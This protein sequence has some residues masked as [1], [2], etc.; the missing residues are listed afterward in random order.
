VLALGA[1]LVALAAAE[2]SLWLLAPVADPYASLKVRRAP[3]YVL[4]AN[5]DLRLTTDVEPGLPGMQGPSRFTTNRLGFGGDSLRI[6]KPPGELRVFLIG[7][8][9]TE[10]LYLD[11]TSSL[12]AVVQRELQRLAGDAARIQVYG[13]GRSGAKT[14]DHVSVFVHRIAL[15]EPDLIVVFA[16]VNDLLAAISG[17]DPLHFPA[18]GD[19]VGLLALLRVTATELQLPR[20]MYYLARGLRPV[21]A[22]QRLEAIPLRSAYGPLVTL[23]RQGPPAG[24]APPVPAAEFRT[25]LR[26]LIG[27][28]RL[29]GVRTVLMTQQTTWASAVDPR[30]EEWQWLRYRGGVTFDARSMD[31]AMEA[32]NDIMRGLALELDV[33]LY[34]LARSVPKSLDYFYD[35]VH[36]NLRGA[37]RAGEEL[38]AVVFEALSP[39]DR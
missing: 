15:L 30:V 33:P 12:D 2:A 21:T 26:S 5:P 14:D 24:A 38:A 3:D 34:D 9:T 11:D 22:T 32:L 10:C 4:A 8:S 29:N 20:R 31:Q 36:F 37:R 18:A 19:S 28:A 25:N 1:T 16:G 6:P 7:G 27:A 39:G 17:H 13:A 23:R 35:D